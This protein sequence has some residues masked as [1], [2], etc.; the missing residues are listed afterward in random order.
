MAV[1]IICKENVER[2]LQ[3][4]C[5]EFERFEE[6][7]EENEENEKILVNYESVIIEASKLLNHLK[8][9]IKGHQQMLEATQRENQ[10]KAEAKERENQ[11]K[12]EA[13]E[14]EN[15]RKAELEQEKLRID[16]KVQLEKVNLERL[17]IEAD[18]KL[19]KEKLESEVRL[20]EAETKKRDTNLE[21][22]KFRHEVEELTAQNHSTVSKRTS[23]R[24]PRIE[25]KI[26]GGQIIKWKNFG[27][28]LK[29]LYTRIRRY[30]QS[31]SSIT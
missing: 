18:A 12:A 19:Q 11:R 16:E 6:T 21:I 28:H 15:Q 4:Y 3:K 23:G 13:E 26:F 25:L 7:L 17:K 9:V 22:D 30:N 29:L 8:G 27:T 24:L 14:R 10:R 20:R 2:Q 31:K 1:F 5:K